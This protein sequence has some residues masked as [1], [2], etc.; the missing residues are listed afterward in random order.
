MNTT[1]QSYY[2]LK[3]PGDNIDKTHE[4]YTLYYLSEIFKELNDYL[5]KALSMK[6]EEVK[7]DSKKWQKW[8]SGVAGLVAGGVTVAF[9]PGAA[10]GIIIGTQVAK[11]AVRLLHSH[12]KSKESKMSK[13]KEVKSIEKPNEKQSKIK[14]KFKEFMLNENYI[15]NINWFLNGA[16]IGAAA[17]GLYNMTH[18]DLT[19]GLDETITTDT[20]GQTQVDPYSQIKIG[21]NASGLD[22][23]QGYDQAHWAANNINS[24][25]KIGDG[26]SVA[27]AFFYR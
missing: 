15:K 8:L 14:Q 16:T 11:T 24:E 4:L 23:T 13:E 9:A 26:R 10:M 19:P 25:T 2:T 6:I 3:S 7:K 17:V 5:E 18:P 20:I 12:L 21:D 1:C 22:L 27:V